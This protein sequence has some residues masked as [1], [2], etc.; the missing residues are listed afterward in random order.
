M[1]DPS[2]PQPRP[3][4]APFADA[5][6]DRAAG[7]LE[8]LPHRQVG[9]FWILR[10]VIA[11]VVLQ[12]IHSPRCVGASILEFVPPAPGATLTGGRPGIRVDPELE[13]LRV[14]VVRERPHSGRKA[15]R[16][17]NDGAVRVPIHLPAVV[18]YDVLVAGIA[19]P[20]RH[21][22]V[23]RL[24]DQRLAHVA[25]ES[26]PAVPA[27]RRC[28]RES[29]EGILLRFLGRN[30]H[31]RNDF[32]QRCDHHDREATGPTDGLHYQPSS[33]LASSGSIASRCTITASTR[34]AM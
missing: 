29:F 9:C 25:A 27:H 34:S 15:L 31:A 13:P 21:H 20:A 10:S 23:C 18:Y 6:H 14:Y 2:G 32:E 5:E 11:P 4:R 8:R 30:R 17:D 16:I 28:R 1:T 19:H 7:C 33:R 12:V 3:V 24:P 26:V 22:G